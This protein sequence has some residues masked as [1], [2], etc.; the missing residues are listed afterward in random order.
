MGNRIAAVSD[1][2]TRRAAALSYS[3]ALVGDGDEAGETHSDDGDEAGSDDSDDGDA[4]RS[5]ISEEEQK[6]LDFWTNGVCLD[7][8]YWV[9]TPTCFWQ[10]PE[11]RSKKISKDVCLVIISF[12]TNKCRKSLNEEFPNDKEM[13]IGLYGKEY[14]DKWGDYQ[15]L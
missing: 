7:C 10:L 5:Q 13:L 1:G 11:I 2:S 12:L 6:Q 3:M 9:G 15:G 4:P 14:M 8:M